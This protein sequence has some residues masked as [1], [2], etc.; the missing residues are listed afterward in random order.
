M[1]APAEAPRRLRPPPDA[2]RVSCEQGWLAYWQLAPNAYATCAHGS[3][4]R[5]MSTL[6]VK[7]G[8]RLY[9]GGR[10]VYGFHDWLE[11]TNYES[12]SRSDLTSWVLRHRNESVLHVAVRSPLVAMGVSVADMLLGSLIHIHRSA[13]ALD[14]ALAEAFPLR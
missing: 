5:E 8:E 13:P 2:K 3:M 7:H 12:A 9:E 11:M 10:V 1:G 14:Q 4:T 6:I